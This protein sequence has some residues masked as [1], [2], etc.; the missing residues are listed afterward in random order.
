MRISMLASPH[1]ASV[2]NIQI[3]TFPLIWKGWCGHKFP[4]PWFKSTL[5]KKTKGDTY[6][7]SCLWRTARTSL[8][9]K[10]LRA[11][12]ASTSACESCKTIPLHFEMAETGQHLEPVLLSVRLVFFRNSHARAYARETH[13][14]LSLS[15]SASIS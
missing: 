7:T 4:R 13:S 1:G 6:A 3:D 2:E 15:V 8:S 11:L 12:R 9:K 10:R 5:Q 14:K